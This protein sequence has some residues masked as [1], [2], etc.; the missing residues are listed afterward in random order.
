MHRLIVGRTRSGKSALAKQLGSQLRIQGHEIFA[1]NPTGEPGYTRKDEYGCIA[2]DW[3]TPDPVAFHDACVARLAENA[4]RF[5]IIV[6]EAHE[7]FARSGAGDFLWVG[8]RGRHYG[9]NIIAISQRGAAINPTFR[10]QCSTLY[11]FQ[12]SLTDARFLSDEYG[13]VELQDAPTLPAGTCLKIENN[14]VTKLRVY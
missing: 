1:F 4:G 10:G 3:E 5:F 13:C 14:T 9:I 7:F 8:T 12:C 11:C 2:A 6:D